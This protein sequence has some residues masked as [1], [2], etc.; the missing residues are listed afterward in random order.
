MCKWNKSV[1]FSYYERLKCECLPRK[2]TPF[3][4][5]EYSTQHWNNQHQFSNQVLYQRVRWLLQT[6]KPELTIAI[7]VSNKLVVRNISIEWKSQK[8][9]THRI[10]GMLMLSEWFATM[11]M[12]LKSKV[13]IRS[14]YLSK[15][16]PNIRKNIEEKPYERLGECSFENLSPLQH[17]RN[18]LSFVIA[19]HFKG[20]I[21]V[22]HKC[23]GFRVCQIFDDTEL[24]FRYNDSHHSSPTCLRRWGFFLKTSGIQQ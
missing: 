17:E 23:F 19:W 4:R 14:W 13:Y 7:D 15:K 2:K 6:K 18:T 16:I 21:G 3:E 20:N 5:V 12:N 24:W 11:T 9:K 10:F 22:N 8:R 1:A